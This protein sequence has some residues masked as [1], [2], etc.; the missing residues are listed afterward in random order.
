MLLYA[1]NVQA[2]LDKSCMDRFRPGQI[3][4]CWPRQP[5]EAEF[6]FEDDFL[7]LILHTRLR[8]YHFYPGQF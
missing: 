4:S 1:A 8:H 7:E 2:L 6:E 5:I 3:R